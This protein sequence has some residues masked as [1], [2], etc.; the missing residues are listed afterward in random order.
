MPCPILI[1]IYCKIIT[2]QL[3]FDSVYNL[4]INTDSDSL[5]VTSD[6]LFNIF[7]TFLLFHV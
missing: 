4:P 2:F 3:H 7:L 5:N 1:S 6:I